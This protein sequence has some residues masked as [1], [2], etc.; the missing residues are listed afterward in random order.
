M[1]TVNPPDIEPITAA[2]TVPG[3]QYTV[4]FDGLKPSTSYNYTIRI[5]SNFGN[6]IHVVES[7]TGEFS[8]KIITSSQ[9]NVAKYI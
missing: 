9:L 3:Q 1:T 4:V 8:S 6:T 7:V 5:V 2:Y